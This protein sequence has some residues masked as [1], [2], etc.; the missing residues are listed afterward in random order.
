LDADRQSDG[1]E[2]L[3]ARKFDTTAPSKSFRQSLVT[4]MQTVY[5]VTHPDVVIDPVVPVPDWPLSQ[6]GRERMARALELPWVGGIRAVW[7]S[8]ERKARDG[9]EILAGHLS[10]PVTELVALGEN[11]RSAT[12][13]VPRTEFEA[14][15]DLFFAYPDRSARGWERAAHAQ[16]RIVNAVGRLRIASAG[17]GGDIAIVSYGGVG[18]LL[19]CHFRGVAIARQ[20]DQPP[21]NGGNYFAYDAETG[22][23]RHGW[24]PIDG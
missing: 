24:R 6:R 4:A 17:C 22:A 16:R 23:L 5:F 20:H 8:T 12:R 15:A 1:E 11:G 2:L 10:I 9:A 21:N 14:A 19:L 3:A 7:C 18:T 13:Y